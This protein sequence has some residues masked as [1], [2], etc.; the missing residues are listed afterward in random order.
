VGRFGA[1]GLGGEGSGHVLW[2]RRGDPDVAA[3]LALRGDRLAV[4][5]TNLRVFAV[6]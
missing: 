4:A 1:G 5:S 3:A 6:E 2:S